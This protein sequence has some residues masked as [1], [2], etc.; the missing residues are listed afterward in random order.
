M[1]HQPSRW[2]QGS[3]WNWEDGKILKKTDNMKNKKNLGSCILVY[4]WMDKEK[5]IK[6]WSSLSLYCTLSVD[7]YNLWAVRWIACA[8][9]T[10]SGFA[11]FILVQRGCRT[12]SVQAWGSQCTMN[13]SIIS[14]TGLEFF[15]HKLC[16]SPMTDIFQNLAPTHHTHVSEISHCSKQH[17][18][19]YPGKMN[20]HRRILAAL[21]FSYFPV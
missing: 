21:L 16:L 18:K 19:K 13:V 3:Q 14:T 20:M 7:S 9:L 4:I 12:K 10:A 17:W 8:I 6:V 11:S 15:P 2:A 5:E 1:R